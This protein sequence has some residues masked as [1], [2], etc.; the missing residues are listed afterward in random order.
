MRL[1]NRCASARSLA[2]AHPPGRTTN[3]KRLGSPDEH[4]GVSEQDVER[5][6]Q[7]CLRLL[8]IRARSE[9]E[10]HS[11]L[12]R[13]GTAPPVA[14]ECLASLRRVGLLD[15]AA[16]ASAWVESRMRLRPVGKRALMRQLALK[17]IE[18]ALAERAVGSAVTP[19]AELEAALAL[20]RRYLESGTD[21]A[22]LRRAQA[23]LARR[24]FDSGIIWQVIESLSA[25]RANR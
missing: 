15:D 6:K 23:A 5:A 4:P 21:R 13:R 9:H 20:G 8:A 12:R 25:H 19:E 2:F 17:G 1:R 18:R 7:Y 14:E 10:L 11:S 16:F 24:G 22:A 3:R